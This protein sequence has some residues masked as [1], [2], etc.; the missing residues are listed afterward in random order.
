MQDRV[1]KNGK[2]ADFR[3]INRCIWMR[4]EKHIAATEE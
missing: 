1:G 4:K 3:P 2:K